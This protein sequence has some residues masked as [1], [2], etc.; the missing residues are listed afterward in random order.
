MAAILKA[1]FGQRLKLQFAHNIAT[2]AQTARDVRQLP[3]FQE[4]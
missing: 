3:D 2:V 4:L 1:P